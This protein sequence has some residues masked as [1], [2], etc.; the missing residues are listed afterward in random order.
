M[1]KAKGKYKQVI[2]FWIPVDYYFIND[3]MCIQRITSHSFSFNDY[4]NLL[5]FFARV[6]A[7]MSGGSRASGLVP[8]LLSKGCEK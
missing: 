1:I 7:G 5:Q 2:K 3:A 6:S 4:K 8:C